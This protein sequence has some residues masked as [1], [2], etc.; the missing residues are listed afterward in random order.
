VT[1]AVLTNLDAAINSN[2]VDV[3]IANGNISGFAT[4]TLQGAGLLYQVII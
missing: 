2:R 4:A 1:N 3:N